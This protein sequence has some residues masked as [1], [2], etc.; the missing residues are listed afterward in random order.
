MPLMSGKHE[1]GWQVDK[2]TKRKLCKKLDMPT[3]HAAKK[4]G[5]CMKE[6]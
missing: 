6:D 5:I 2:L 1:L 4:S 3:H